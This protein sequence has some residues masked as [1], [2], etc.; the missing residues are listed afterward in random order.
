MELSCLAL[1]LSTSPSSLPMRSLP[2]LFLYLT[3]PYF[4][5]P[6]LSNGGLI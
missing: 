1:L 3:P 5:R 6:M 2:L 4:P